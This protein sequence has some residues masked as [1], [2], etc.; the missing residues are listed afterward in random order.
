MSKSTAARSVASPRSLRGLR[1]GSLW[2]GASLPE[3]SERGEGGSSTSRCEV[4]S[5]SGLIVDGLTAAAGELA[6]PVGESA[7]AGGRFARVSATTMAPLGALSGG[8]AQ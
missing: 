1:K 5:F 4:L 3:V 8:Y 6:V 7:P 2:G